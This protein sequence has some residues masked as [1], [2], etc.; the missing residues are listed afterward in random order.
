MKFPPMIVMINRYTAMAVVRIRAG[1]R[2][3]TIAEVTPTH[4]SPIT[5]E[6]MSV[7]KHH[8]NGR[9]SAPAANGAA[10]SYRQRKREVVRNRKE[11]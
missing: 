6:G 3:T 11:R 4:I 2:S 1:A 8:G 7:R 9:N 5:L 10:R